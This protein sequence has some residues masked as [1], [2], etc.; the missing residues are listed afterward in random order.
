MFSFVVI[1]GFAEFVSFLS[2]PKWV[3][4][5]DTGHFRF[6]GRNRRTL[7][8]GA[9]AA[10]TKLLRSVQR[11]L[12]PIEHPALRNAASSGRCSATGPGLG[13]APV[14]PLQSCRGAP[15]VPFAQVVSC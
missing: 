9:R 15:V 13:A 2:S 5:S 7:I 12:R 8:S 11:L 3:N 6:F 4:F 14:L 10:S 1:F